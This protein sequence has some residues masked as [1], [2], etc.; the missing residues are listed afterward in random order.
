MSTFALEWR[1]VQVVFLRRVV[2]DDLLAVMIG[3][4]LL[5]CSKEEL[6][7]V[8]AG[9]SDLKFECELESL[10]FEYVLL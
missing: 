6:L 7:V 9:C 10:N 2:Q 4:L 5:L 3:V 8:A 1:N